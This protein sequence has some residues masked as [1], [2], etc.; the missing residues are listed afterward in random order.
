MVSKTFLIFNDLHSFEE[1]ESDILSNVPELAFV[2]C[3]LIKVGLCVLGRKTIEVNCHFHHILAK[4]NDISM[5]SLWVL[6]LIWVRYTDTL[7]IMSSHQPNITAFFLT[8]HYPL[9]M[10]LFSHSKTL[11]PKK[12]IYLF[13][14][15][16]LWCT[17]NSFETTTLKLLGKAIY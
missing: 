11:A 1:F 9:F 13:I 16:I 4:V 2:W 10:S 6:T 5:P 7:L 3:S 14:C 15:S 17:Q 12:S 8:F